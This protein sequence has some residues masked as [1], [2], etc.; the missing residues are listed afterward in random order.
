MPR[1]VQDFKDHPYYA[2]ERHLKHNEVIHP[3][4][5]VG[6]LTTGKGAPEPIYRRSDVQLV[7]SA[8]KWYRSGRELKVSYLLPPSICLQYT[9]SISSLENNLSNTAQPVAQ[10]DEVDRHL[11]MTLLT[12][13]TS[14][15]LH[16]ILSTKPISTFPPQSQ[17][18]AS[19]RTPSAISTFTFHP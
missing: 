6:K 2:I 14:R 1:N 18:V 9:N 3:K 16:Y 17:R 5:E 15:A 19:P 13:V 12:R 10:H 7:R 8:D 11:L 4:R